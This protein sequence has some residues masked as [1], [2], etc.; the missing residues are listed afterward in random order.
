M[1]EAP[2]DFDRW[3]VGM[4][5]T[6]ASEQAISFTIWE[7]PAMR[8]AL[9]ERDVATVYLMLQRI[10]VS[11]RRIAALTGQSQSEIS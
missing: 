3:K 8:R 2:R 4:N 6:H 9:A 1:W 7:R 11:Q 5:V 10:G